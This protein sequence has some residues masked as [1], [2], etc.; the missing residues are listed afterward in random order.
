MEQ[1]GKEKSPYHGVL[2]NCIFLSG[3]PTF[4]YLLVRSVIMKYQ[5]FEYDFNNYSSMVIGFG[6]GF[7][8]QI[9]CVVAGLTKGTFSV[10][11]R[12]VAN[13]FEDLSVS[14][15]FAIK[16]Y[17]SDIKENGIVFWIYFLLIGSCLA[18]T[19][20]ALV[21]LLTKYSYYLM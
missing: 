16:F 17:I 14:F 2:I 9:S 19:V 13:L 20:A 4:F 6:A 7:L 18:T 15:R 1:M 21:L 11:V 10:V 5:D 3:V 12:R 8:F